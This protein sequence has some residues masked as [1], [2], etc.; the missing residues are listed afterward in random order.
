MTVTAVVFDL[1]GV[2][3][4]S[5]L[6]AFTA[7][8][9]EAGLPEGAARVADEDLLCE[10]EVWRVEAACGRMFSRGVYELVHALGS[11]SWRLRAVVD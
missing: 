10:Q 1:G 2:I 8:E 4:E 11:G 7:Y 3:T 9:R 6:T 5:P